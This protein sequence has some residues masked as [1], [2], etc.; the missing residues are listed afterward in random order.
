MLV[1]KE[2]T[3]EL[4]YVGV[5]SQRPLSASI[6]TLKRS[7]LNMEMKIDGT[8]VLIAICEYRHRQFLHVADVK[9]LGRQR[10]ALLK[11]QA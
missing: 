2:G 11:C 1:W 4:H 3:H 10:R 6:F 9:E 5:L 7:E 8:Y